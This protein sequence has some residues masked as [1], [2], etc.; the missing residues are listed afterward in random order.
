METLILDQFLLPINDLIEAII[1]NNR[2]VTRLEPLVFCDRVFSRRWVVLFANVS[3]NSKYT[4]IHNPYQV[5]FH[6]C[7]TSNP[8]FARLTLLRIT[9][10]VHD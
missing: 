9:T 3:D 4:D 6:D 10:V 8:K 2:D 5:S 7:R 1:V